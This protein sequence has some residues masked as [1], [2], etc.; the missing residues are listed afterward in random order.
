[1][2]A[3]GFARGY[4][5]HFIAAVFLTSIWVLA[6]TTGGNL[7]YLSTPFGLYFRA[8]AIFPLLLGMGIWLGFFRV[9]RTTGLTSHGALTK[10]LSA[11][12]RYL[13]AAKVLVALMVMSGLISYMSSAFSALAAYVMATTPFARTYD[14][15]DVKSFRA[16]RSSTTR[17]DIQLMRVPGP[18]RVSLRFTDT[19]LSG[20]D[21]AEGARVCVVGRSS[22]FGTI[23]ESVSRNLSACLRQTKGTIDSTSG[24][25]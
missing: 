17:Y 13:S 12:K 25:T 2:A 8:L 6:V 14:V 24:A 3:M 23:V 20:R 18:E 16:S 4:W 21:W 19:A 11:R 7:P 5:R 9:W 15:L 1:M 10:G 22:L